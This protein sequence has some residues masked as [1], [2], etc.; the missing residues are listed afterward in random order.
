MA[1]ADGVATPT[2]NF[3]LTLAFLGAVPES[4]TREL[5][6]IATRVA[7]A[8]RAASIVVTLDSID[9]WRKSEILCA[10]SNAES[11]EAMALAEALHSELTDS[12]WGPDRETSQFR[13][14]VTLARKVRRRVRPTPMPS[15]AWTFKEFALVESQTLPTG[16]VYRVLETFPLS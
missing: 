14:H 5:G 15:L 10:T 12:G 1:A 7:S 2:H 8:F 11:V 4:R 13:P 6:E 3:H 16:S 9:Y